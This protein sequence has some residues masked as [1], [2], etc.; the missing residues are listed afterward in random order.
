[1]G[2]LLAALYQPM[3][4]EGI[5]DARDVA[6]VTAGIILLALARLPSW[7]VVAAMGAAGHWILH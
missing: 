1:V 7:A 3:C 2:I 4:T 6:A 5:R